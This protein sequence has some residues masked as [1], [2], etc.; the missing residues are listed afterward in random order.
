MRSPS[1]AVH[2]LLL[3]ALLLVTQ[4]A[5]ATVIYRWVDENGRTHISDS[6]PEKYKKS[7]TRI[8]SSRSEV[9][10]EQRKEAQDIA[11]KE[12]ALAEEAAKQRLSKQASQPASAASLPTPGKRPAQGVT[13]STDCDTWRRL[14]NESL[15][16]F[17]PYRTTRGA[18]KPEAFEKCT[19]I[20][21]PEPKC[22]PVRE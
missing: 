13:D 1:P 9:T 20:P 4:A 21:S 18:T 11:A 3:A 5:Q 6:V 15:E 2:N 19:T 10:P 14:Y 8:D 22:G 17:G 7:A 16:C 12:K